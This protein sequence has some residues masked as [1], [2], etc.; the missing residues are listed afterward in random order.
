MKIQD[1]VSLRVI[2]VS[3]SNDYLSI[4]A[5]WFQKKSEAKIF[6]NYINKYFEEKLENK[7]IVVEFKKDEDNF[8]FIFELFLDNFNYKIEISNINDQYVSDLLYTM[9]NYNS[10]TIVSGYTD[11]NKKNHIL[12][13]CVYNTNRLF[14]NG[15]LLFSEPYKKFPIHLV[16]KI[17]R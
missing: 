4:L 10:L 15:K 17:I 13:N 2:K 16:E 5:L 7:K 3:D 12:K 9:E 1:N 6:F 11:K 8:I 14:L